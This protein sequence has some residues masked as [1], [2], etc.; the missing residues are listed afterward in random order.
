[1]P[2][3]VVVP[4]PDD[5]RSPVEEPLAL[6]PVAKSLLESEPELQPSSSPNTVTAARGQRCERRSTRD[7]CNDRGRLSSP[8][9]A[10]ISWQP[11]SARSRVRGTKSELGR[12]KN[13]G[14]IF[15]GGLFCRFAEVARR[16]PGNQRGEQGIHRALV[17]GP[18]VA[19]RGHALERPFEVELV[20]GG[21]IAAIASE[22]A[23][24]T[25]PIPNATRSERPV[26]AQAQSRARIDDHHV[27]IVEL[28]RALDGFDEARKLVRRFTCSS[29]IEP[30]LSMT[31]RKSIFPHDEDT[32]LSWLPVSQ[33]ATSSLS[34]V[35]SS[36]GTSG[37]GA[38]EGT[39]AVS[40]SMGPDW[41]TRHR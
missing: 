11:G 4:S 21:R 14:A 41:K 19:A 40:V 22:V 30:E 1:M 17:A 34:V 33:S 13:R 31:N 27:K 28:D 20:V 29:C 9:C 37:P 18:F 35:P 12:R 26:A 23:Q 6:A 15:G 2:P 39:G 32:P 24:G 38:S 8:R 25:V 36:F 5:E 10:A 16:R 7:R 3:V